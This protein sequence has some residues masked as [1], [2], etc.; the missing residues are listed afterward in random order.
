MVAGLEYWQHSLEPGFVPAYVTP[1]G[2]GFPPLVAV[3]V[4]LLLFGIEDVRDVYGYRSDNR[5]G[6]NG[7][8]PKH[9]PWGFVLLRLRRMMLIPVLS[10]AVYVLLYYPHPLIETPYRPHLLAAFFALLVSR[11]GLNATP[12]SGLRTVGVFYANI[13]AAFGATA[14]QSEMPKRPLR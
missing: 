2:W 6:V 13:T 3:T 12:L 14:N 10:V 1:E 5:E 7:I 8:L 11:R 4:L 9:K